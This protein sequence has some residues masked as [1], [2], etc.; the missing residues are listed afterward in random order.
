ML[1]EENITSI[2]WEKDTAC[3][4]VLS[5]SD[6]ELWHHDLCISIIMCAKQY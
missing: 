4:I 1:I 2:Y 5:V 6:L 3:M